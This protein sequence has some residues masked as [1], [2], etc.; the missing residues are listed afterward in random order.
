MIMDDKLFFSE[1]QDLSQTEAAYSSTNTLDKGVGVDE[2]GTAKVAS[3]GTGY[4]S[5][6]NILVTE[7][8]NSAGT[9]TVAIKLQESA[10]D[11]DWSDT[12]ISIGAVAFGTLTA[13][14]LIS[15]KL[16]R[17]L[18]R[19]LKLVYTIGGATTTYGKITSWLGHPGIDK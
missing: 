8:F 5:D 11:S 14:T 3:E 13:G 9:A 2:F 19:Y 17:G 1:D 18:K 15:V 4:G 12:P 10:N 16:P 7:T 6:L